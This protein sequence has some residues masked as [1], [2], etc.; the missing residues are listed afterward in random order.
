MS[1][2]ARELTYVRTDGV[3]ERVP[4]KPVPPVPADVGVTRPSRR[5]V[6]IVVAR[7]A[8]SQYDYLAEA[9]TGVGW[10]EVIVDRRY[11]ERRALD[12]GLPLDPR[13]RDR[14][15]RADVEERL[16]TACWAVVSVADGR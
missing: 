3:V 5:R 15:Q 9:F 12:R 13:Q 10:A 8:Q 1:G 4:A 16:R 2:V 6:L 11:G 14:R 7:D